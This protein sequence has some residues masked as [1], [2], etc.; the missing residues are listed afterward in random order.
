MSSQRQFV[1]YLERPSEMQK[2]L[3]DFCESYNR[4]SSEFPD[5]LDNDETKD[6]LMNRIQILSQ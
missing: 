1:N 6:E 4:F 5:L 3:N 2:K